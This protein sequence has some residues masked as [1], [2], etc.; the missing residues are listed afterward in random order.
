[1]T[2][3]IELRNITA[4]CKERVPLNGLNLKVDQGTVHAI[5][6]ERRS[7]KSSIA[8]LLDGNMRLMNGEI[9]IDRKSLMKISPQIMMHEKVGVFHQTPR[10]IPTLT[11]WENVASGHMSIGISTHRMRNEIEEKILSICEKW[12]LHPDLRLPVYKLNRIESTLIELSRALIFSPRVLMID[13]PLARFTSDEVQVLY[14][15]ITQMKGSKCSIL[16]V[17]STV[18]E[19]LHIA[20]ELSIIKSGKILET[21]PTRSLDREDMVDLAYSFSESREELVSKNIRLLKYKKYNEEIISNLPLGMI[22]FDGEGNIYLSNQAALEILSINHLI[23]SITSDDYKATFEEHITMSGLQNSLG[24]DI[25]I[26]IIQAMKSGKQ[27]IWKQWPTTNGKFI[28]I[29]LYPFHDNLKQLA[30]TI[31]VL[32]DVTEEKLTREYLTRTDRASS[33]AQLAAGIVHEVNNPLGIISNYVELLLMRAKDNYSRERLEVIKKEIQRISSSMLSLLS[34]S[35]IDSSTLMTFDMNQVV[36]ETFSL[37]EYEARRLKIALKINLPGEQTLVKMDQSRI[38]QVLI[39]LILNALDACSAGGEIM[40]SLSKKANNTVLLQIRDNGKGIPKERI[41]SLF[42]PFLSEK[43][44]K[45]HAGLGLFICK[46]ITE[47]HGG[48]IWCESQPGCTTFFI[49]LPCEGPISPIK[50]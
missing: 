19:V 36:S 49:E 33:I 4:F 27:G 3:G 28:N 2:Q 43:N 41:S 47:A 37:L 38:K 12:N 11:P 40:V 18:D 39:N 1:M 6:G 14:S 9:I 22:F 29:M 15:I 45:A 13:E 48:R 44:S 23:G 35:S 24:E 32:Q 10:I 42:T 16:Y 8:S 20:D 46:Q 34:F 50:I 26:E 21:Q 30:G 7:G 25:L 31:L 17:A 5:I